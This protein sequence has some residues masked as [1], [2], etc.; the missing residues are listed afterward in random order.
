MDIGSLFSLHS[1]DDYFAQ[2]SCC[3][4]IEFKFYPNLSSENQISAIFKFMYIYP[5]QH[6]FL[7]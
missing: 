3:H 7:G 2:A 1:F 5:C 6:D 4:I